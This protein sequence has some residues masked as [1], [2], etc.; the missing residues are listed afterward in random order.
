MALDVAGM[1]TRPRPRVADERVVAVLVRRFSCLHRAFLLA[2]SCGVMRQ[3]RRS[4]D[5]VD[6]AWDCARWR[7]R[8]SGRLTRAGGCRTVPGTGRLR[9]RAVAGRRIEAW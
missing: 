6:S 4:L 5:E 9:N 1:S 7:T 8:C 3:C 2:E